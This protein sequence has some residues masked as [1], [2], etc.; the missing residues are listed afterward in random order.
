[1]SVV[2]IRVK[3]GL[4]T[5]LRLDGVYYDKAENYKK[6]N[7]EISSSH[8]I[9]D[10]IVYQSFL[11]KR[12]CEKYLESRKAKFFDVIYNG[13][14]KWNNFKEHD[15]I[16]VISCSKWR[17]HKRLPEIVEI[18]KE[19]SKRCPNSKLHILGPMKRGATEIPCKNAVY[20]GKVDTE[21]IKEI[22]QTGD[23]YLH[24]SKRDSCPSS[25]I[26]A[27]SSRIPVITTSVCGG[28]AEICDFTA[29]CFVVYGELN[30]LEPDYIYQDPFNEISSTIMG[31]IVEFMTFVVRNRVRS[32]LPTELTIDHTAEKYILI[33]MKVRNENS[34]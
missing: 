11:S 30:S 25:V 3:N 23:V 19:F 9:A 8:A 18:F 26:E 5:V 4:P 10:G 28:A 32:L 22:Y 20:Y 14:E 1:L 2:R 27:I 12:M 13:V 33:L 21:R 6:K 16:N 29:G 31:K 7:A 17:R 34:V 24:L 15:G